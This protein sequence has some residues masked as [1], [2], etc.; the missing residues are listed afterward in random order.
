MAKHVTC[1]QS[2]PVSWKVLA[3]SSC[4]GSQL[5]IENYYI[6]PDRVIWF[7]LL[8]TESGDLIEGDDCALWSL[9]WRQHYWQGWLRCLY[10]SVVHCTVYR[11]G[12]ACRVTSPSVRQAPGRTRTHW[13]YLTLTY[14]PEPRTTMDIMIMTLYCTLMWSTGLVSNT[15]GIQWYSL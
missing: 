14:W 2:E 7:W 4:P 10:C 12:G 5:L 1:Y 15:L 13:H 3:L 6:K 11:Q 9:H 8:N